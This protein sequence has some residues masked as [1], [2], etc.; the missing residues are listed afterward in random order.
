M[1]PQ[2]SRHQGLFILDKEGKLA[3]VVTRGDVLRALGNDPS[4][5]LSVLEAGSRK[6][7]VT[8]PDEVSA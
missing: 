4:G 7:V 1:I 3:G 2:S 5:S 8:Y 6:V